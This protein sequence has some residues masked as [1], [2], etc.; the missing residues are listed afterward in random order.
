MEVTANRS[1]ATWNRL[2][3]EEY[4]SYANLTA[5]DHPRWSQHT[6]HLIGKNW[7][8]HKRPTEPFNGRAGEVADLCRGMDL[9]R[10]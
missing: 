9:N 1:A 5:V 10:S 8:V 3:P 4:G 7:L 2:Q 6:H